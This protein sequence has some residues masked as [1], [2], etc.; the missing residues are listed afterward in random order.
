[1][2][3]VDDVTPLLA[4]M[5]EQ[6]LLAGQP[7]QGLFDLAGE[8]VLDG[9]VTEATVAEVPASAAAAVGQT[10]VRAGVS[11]RVRQVLPQP[12]DGALHQ[13]ILARL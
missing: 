3:F 8:V 9:A 6:L 11:Y 13:L 12:P 10:L 7:V 4:E 5:G 2:A 1:M